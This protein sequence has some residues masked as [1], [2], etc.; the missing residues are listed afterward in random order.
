MAESAAAAMEVHERLIARLSEP[1]RYPHAV[2]EVRLIET[3]ISSVLLTGAYAY[4]IKKPVDLGFLDFSTLEK[5]R[6]YCAEELRLNR[7]L[8]PA[9]YLDLAPIFGSADDPRFEARG[10]PVEYAV[11]MREFPQHSLLDARLVRGELRPENIDALAGAVA[12]FHGRVERAGAAS[13]YGTPAAIEDP[14]RQNFEQIGARLTAEAERAQLAALERWSLEAHRSLIPVFEQRRREGFIRECHGDLHLGNMAWVDGA[15]QVFDG[16]E[17][18]PDLRWIDVA[19]EIAFLVMDLA[20]RGRADYA[21][22]FLDAYLQATGDYDA[23]RV[24][25]YYLVY[26]AMVRSKVARIR[27]GQEHLTAEDRGGALASYAAYIRYAERCIAP[28]RPALV[29]THGFSGSGKTTASQALLQG[30]GAIRLRSDVERKRLEGLPA[31][32]RSASALAA[33]LYSE[34]ATR[35]TYE[36]LARLARL[37]L[38]S[39]HTVIVDATCLKRWQRELL[40]EAALG[41]DVPFVIVDFRAPVAELRR[42]VGE[43]QRLGADASEA[44]AAVLEHQRAMAEPLAGDESALTVTLDIEAHTVEEMVRRVADALARVRP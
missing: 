2:T 23:V 32:A 28:R 16:I 22:R 7:R 11:K 26:R 35:R 1:A 43:R 41:L 24:L 39:G 15:I 29:I 18:S 31:N 5:R 12:A 8:A 3:H 36:E 21:W 37:G 13:G 40:R 38:A 14:V 27:A 4:K 20:E 9:I 19:S 6:F 10:T 17:F 44:T 30:L 42:R 33:G 34:A 25:D